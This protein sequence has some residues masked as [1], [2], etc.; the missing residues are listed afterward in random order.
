[1]HDRYGT[2][3]PAPKKRT[4]VVADPDETIEFHENPREAKDRDGL[5]VFAWAS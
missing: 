2:R 5:T 4:S 1:V 3:C